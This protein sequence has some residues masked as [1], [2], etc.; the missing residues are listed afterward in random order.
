MLLAD[1]LAACRPAQLIVVQGYCRVVS[2][3]AC[4][5]AKLSCMLEGAQLGMPDHMLNLL[6]YL[7]PPKIPAPRG[8]AQLVW[9][10][11]DA[12]LLTAL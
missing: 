7:V 2:T 5:L 12:V 6:Q 4:A 11:E 9:T 3:S 10:F 1:C 8:S